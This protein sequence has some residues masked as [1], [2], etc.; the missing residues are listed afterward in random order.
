[1]TRRAKPRIIVATRS[2][3]TS[4]MLAKIVVTDLLRAAEDLG[5]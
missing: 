2:A 3:A 4:S 5:G 1:M